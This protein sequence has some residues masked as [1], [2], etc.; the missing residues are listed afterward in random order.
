MFI[1]Y[2]GRNTKLFINFTIYKVLM[3]GQYF[4]N[5]NTILRALGDMFSEI[6]NLGTGNQ[7]QAKFF[8]FFW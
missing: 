1:L 2:I 6:T 4:T 8:F 7:D 5:A 3:K